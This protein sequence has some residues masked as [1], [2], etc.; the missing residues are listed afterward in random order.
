MLFRSRR[1]VGYRRA[2][3]DDYQPNDSFL[4]PQELR[5]QLHRLGRSPVGDRPAGTYARQVLDRLLIDL[6][7]AS[8]RLEGNT[9]SRLDTQNLIQFG[10]LAAGK[11]Q[12]EAQMILNHKAAIEML[13]ERSEEHTSELQS[14]MR[15]SYAVFCLKK[16]ITN[17]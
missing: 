11:D 12:L 16:K 3:L 8:S 13:V 6:S 7:W 2:F 5:T 17:Q 1:P 14:L 10:Q 9:Y 15:I 4:L